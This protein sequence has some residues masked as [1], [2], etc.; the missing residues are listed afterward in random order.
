MTMPARK[1]RPTTLDTV[2]IRLSTHVKAPTTLDTVI[3]RLSTH[4]KAPTTLDT[5]IIR[6]S[7]HV[8]AAKRVKHSTSRP[9]LT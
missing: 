3:I 8:K 1:F 9:S 2:I 4:V 5:V 6:L 7:T